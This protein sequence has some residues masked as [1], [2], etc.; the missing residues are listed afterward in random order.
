MQN[1]ELDLKSILIV[2]SL[3]SMPSLSSQLLTLAIPDA[4]RVDLISPTNELITRIS[5]PVFP[6]ANDTLFGSRPLNYTV[7]KIPRE[8]SH[9][10]FKIRIQGVAFDGN[11]VGEIDGIRAESG[12]FYVGPAKP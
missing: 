1:T 6:L 2:V 12:V 3:D 11:V 4:Y 5:D 10:A 9:R 8:L 7:W